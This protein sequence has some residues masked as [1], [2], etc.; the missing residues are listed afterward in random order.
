VA[1]RPIKA[2]DCRKTPDTSRID[3]TVVYFAL[4]NPAG[5]RLMAAVRVTCRPIIKIG[6]VILLALFTS[7]ASMQDAPPRTGAEMVAHERARWPFIVAPDGRVG[8]PVRASTEL[9]RSAQLRVCTYQ[10]GRPRTWE[11]LRRSCR[12][13]ANYCTVFVAAAI[14][15]EMLY[16][17]YDIDNP[18]VAVASDE[19]CT[20]PYRQPTG[21]LPRVMPSN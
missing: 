3:L 11:V 2:S 20:Q 8:I 16:I 12:G 21:I 4:R 15:D 7:G 17:E 13:G 1:V 10:G 14:H 19:S 9:A 6:G 18:P 5:I